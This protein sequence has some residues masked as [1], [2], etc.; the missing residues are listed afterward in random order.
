L[1]V[2]LRLEVKD[3]LLMRESCSYVS[4]SLPHLIF[5]DRNLSKATTFWGE[6]CTCGD[7]GFA[8]LDVHSPWS[9]IRSC[10]GKMNRLICYFAIEIPPVSKQMTKLLPQESE[11]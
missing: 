9:E 3:H 10:E 6:I 2:K 1:V 4:D 5:T 11:V 8:K 7:N